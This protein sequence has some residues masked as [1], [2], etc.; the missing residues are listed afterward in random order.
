MNVNSLPR[1]NC[2]IP[3][4]N[5]KEFTEWAYNNS[6]LPKTSCNIPMPKDTVSFSNK[7]SKLPKTGCDIP[8][9]NTK[10]FAEWKAAQPKEEE[11][12]TILDKIKSFF[13]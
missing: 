6:Q 9:P 2:N 13:K 4:P 3:T 11:K 7:E 8:M 1:T 10:E 12:P 5:T